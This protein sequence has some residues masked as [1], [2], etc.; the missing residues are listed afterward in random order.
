MMGTYHKP[1][2][3]RDVLALKYTFFSHI[4][5]LQIIFLAETGEILF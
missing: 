4:Y 2:F 3:T 5:L 1:A